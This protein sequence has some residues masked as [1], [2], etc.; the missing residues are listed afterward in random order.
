MAQVRSG[1]I[2]KPDCKK[3]YYDACLENMIVQD[4]RYSRQRKYKPLITTDRK[5]IKLNDLAREIDAVIAKYFLSQFMQ[6]EPP[7]IKRIISFYLN[8]GKVIDAYVLN[9]E[10]KK[11]K[12]FD[13]PA[14]IAVAAIRYIDDFI[15]NF[16]WPDIDE[17]DPKELYARFGSFLGE[18][19]ETV[20][21]FDPDMPEKIIKLPLLEMKL[22][23]FPGQELFDKS[24]KQLIQHKAYDLAYVYTRINPESKCELK[25]KDLLKLAVIDYLRDFT[26]KE[27]EEETDF[28]L[29]LYVRDNEINPENLIQYLNEI[30]TDAVEDDS[31][32]FEDTFGE[33]F[34]TA[35]LMLEEAGAETVC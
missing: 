1:K 25:P 29:Y 4:M 3:A 8:T 31:R 11:Q 24:F 34:N 33:F 32:I 17:Y 7:P 14:F 16:L 6:F 18:V 20:R 28:N 22:A 21:G 15:D 10:K 35:V 9:K 13:G 19:L 5:K 23:L 30:Y 12:G 27:M 26:E 2:D